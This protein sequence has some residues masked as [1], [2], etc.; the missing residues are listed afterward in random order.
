[1]TT[2]IEEL[3]DKAMLPQKEEQ[4]GKKMDQVEKIGKLED[5]SKKPSIWR[6]V[7]E[8]EKTEKYRGGNE[9]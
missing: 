6:E 8:K 4:N 1:M 2:P 9:Q 7:L 5:H 3:E